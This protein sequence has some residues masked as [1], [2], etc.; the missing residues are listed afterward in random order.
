MSVFGGGLN[1]NNDKQATT[2]GGLLPS[3]LQHHDQ[4]TPPEPSS[5]LKS[6]RQLSSE[7]STLDGH[8]EDPTSDANIGRDLHQLARTMSR[9]SS[10]AP[11]DLAHNNP[12]DPVP[13]SIL[14]PF[15]TKD[16]FDPKAWAKAVWDLQYTGDKAPPTRK[17]GVAFEDL[18]VYGYGTDADYQTTVGNA[19]LKA[20]SALKG[21]AGQSGKRR[22]D[23]LQGV[24]GYLEPGE[25]LVVLGP[26]GSYVSPSVP[27]FVARSTVLTLLSFSSSHSGC[28]SF[29]KTLANETHG[30]FVS[31]ETKLNYRGITRKQ[32][33]NNFQ[34]EAI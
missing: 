6:S 4:S 19:P 5:D 9:R 18:S 33:Q 10:V 17:A 32:M 25:M 7:E 1:T 21:L 23:I 28:S 34:G 11:T 22:V 15:T 27:T 29:L 12:L 30:F 16:N 8:A 26:P 13:D 2:N 3:Y 20:W 14:D 31:D 24:D